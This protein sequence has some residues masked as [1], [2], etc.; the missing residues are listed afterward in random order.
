MKVLTTDRDG[1]DD[2]LLIT[3]IVTQED[4]DGAED[5]RG[6]GEKEGQKKRGRKKLSSATF[7]ISTTRS[8]AETHKRTATMKRATANWDNFR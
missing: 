4:D 2:D 8:A 3:E 1:V 6:G 7:N 5:E